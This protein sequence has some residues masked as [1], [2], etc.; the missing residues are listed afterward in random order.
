MREIKFR[1]KGQT[2]KKWHS[3][4]VV[5]IKGDI[6]H[7]KD[8][9]TTWICDITTLG[10]FTGLHDMNGKEIYEG[11]ICRNDGNL[12]G[13]VVFKDQSFLYKYGS[14]YFTAYISYLGDNV[15][16]VG[17]IYENPELLEVNPEGGGSNVSRSNLK[18]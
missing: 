4:L 11:D 15:E 18:D 1:A 9:E 16:V 8:D 10:Q 14:E 17:N 12:V 5:Y 7:I 13:A 6:C 2:D 3:G